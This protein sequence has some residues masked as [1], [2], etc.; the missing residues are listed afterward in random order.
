MLPNY[1]NSQH[2]R[3]HFQ[4]FHE[5]IVNVVVVR[6]QATMKTK[7]FGFV[8]FTS[9]A[10]AAAAI[11]KLNGSKLQGKHELLVQFKHNQERSKESRH[12]LPA[13]PSSRG[14][15]SL[16]SSVAPKGA[17][18]DYTPSDSD[19][20]S[21]PEECVLYIRSKYKVLPDYITR[22]HITEHFK[23]FKKHITN[24][25]IIRDRATNKSKG[26]GFIT[27]SSKASAQ[28]ALRKLN[29]SKLHG[30]F[31]LVIEYKHGKRGAGK[32]RLSVATSTSSASA[33][34]G[35]HTSAEHQSQG[36]VLYIRAKYT[37]LPAYINNQHLKEHFQE[38]KEDIVSA[39]MICDPATRKS[40]G[41]GFITFT[42]VQAA[43][44][45]IQKLNGSK[46]H[47]KFNLLVEF[48][49]RSEFTASPTLIKQPPNHVTVFV[50]CT[51]EQMMYLKLNLFQ[52]T[53]QEAKRLLTSLQ[54]L[55][56]EVTCQQDQILLSGTPVLTEQAQTVILA[57]SLL[58]GLLSHS[59]PFTCHSKFLK[60]IEEHVLEPM[61]REKGLK[62]L[63]HCQEYENEIQGQCSSFTITILSKN[64]AHFQ[65]A[66]MLM[67]PL[68]PQ[69]QRF[70][71]EAYTKQLMPRITEI[72]KKNHRC[73]IQFTDGPT[74]VVQIN[75]LCSHDI[76]SCWKETER[77]MELN[78]MIARRIA[79]ESFQ[80]KY[81]Q[82]KHSELIEKANRVCTLVI[83]RSAESATIG[84]LSIILSGKIVFVKAY[85]ERVEEIVKR[86]T[87]EDVQRLCPTA[88]VSSVWKRRWDSFI[89][90]QQEKYDILVE[91]QCSQQTA[92]KISAST[93]ADVSSVCS[94]GW[95]SFIQELCSQQTA[96]KQLE[97]NA[98]TL[99]TFLVYGSDKIAIRMVKQQILSKS[100]KRL[101][102]SEIELEHLLKGLK[103]KRI[104][105]ES[106]YSVMISVN[107][108]SKEVTL[109]TPPLIKADLSG[110]EEEVLRFIHSYTSITS[111]EMNFDD[112]VI[113]LL[114][115]TS[116]LPQLRKLGEKNNVLVYP[117][118][119]PSLG[120]QLKGTQAA[121][122]IMERGIQQIVSE[123]SRDVTTDQYPVS[124]SYLPMFATPDFTHFVSNLQEELCVACSYPAVGDT[125]SCKV[126]R[127]AALQNPS[128]DVT[129]LQ[130][131]EGSLVKQTVDAIVIEANK[132]LFLTDGLAKTILA[133][134]GPL[135]Q[136]EC[137][138]HIQSK[139]KLQ[140]DT[141][142]CLGSG[143]LPCKKVIHFVYSKSDSTRKLLLAIFCS[144]QCAV[145]NRIGSIAFPAIE[146]KESPQK[147]STLAALQLEAVHAHCTGASGLSLMHSSIHTIR[148]VLSTSQRCEF[149]EAFDSNPHFSVSANARKQPSSV[150]LQ[151]P[152]ASPATCKWFWEDDAKSFSPYPLHISDALTVEYTKNPSGVCSC[153]IDGKLYQIDFQKMK[154]RNVSTGF[155]RN[156]KR[157]QVGD[158]PQ[159]DIQWYYKDDAGH[160]V[161]YSQA[162]SDMIETKYNGGNPTKQRFLL[163][164]HGR[165]YTIDFQSMFQINC[166][167]LH[168][169]SIKREPTKEEEE[170]EE[171]PK[172]R[173]IV[174]NIR[175]CR[176]SLQEARIRIESKLKSLVNKTD[177]PLPPAVPQTFERQLLAVAEKHNLTCRIAEQ[178]QQSQAVAGP[179][180]PKR[181]LRIE[182][183]EHL[184]HKAATE[185]QAEIIQLFQSSRSGADKMSVPPEWQ[186][187]TETVEVFKLQSSSQEWTV[188]SSK[189]SVTMPHVTI[190]KILRI[191]NQWL[192]EKYAQEKSRINQKNAGG[193]NE[194]ELF[195]GTRTNTPEKIYNSEEG[196]DMRYSSQ[197]MWGMANY[198]A[199]NASYSAM[200]AYASISLLGGSS[201][202][203]IF[204]AKVLT[205]D[206]YEC[207]PDKTLRM[208]PQKLGGS[209][210]SEVQLKQV[211]Y[212]SVNGYTRSSQVYMTY[213]NNRAYPAYLIT[214]V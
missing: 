9:H 105:P 45:A 120:I 87:A 201:Q 69:L 154:Q 203:T 177:I 8:T 82:R 175:G 132:D 182:G 204:L 52:E 97:Q 108:A 156:V 4:E 99:V 212:D 150:T 184:V 142:V 191:Q 188:V 115:T 15:S 90:E 42:S 48:Q 3:K 178:Q 40:R 138:T 63:Y 43:E 206:S 78:V 37:V 197:G 11:R 190:T 195:H 144:L 95:D 93:T 151:T 133:E 183:F 136:V 176:K 61:L 124:Y 28:A 66:S 207:E 6:D 55:P 57:S 111:K 23:E 22:Q 148:I 157:E 25:R 149:L 163:T 49:H 160:F 194:M 126:L 179:Q 59:Y 75:G 164:I 173:H 85:A 168:K 137:S 39:R 56:V 210:S 18:C 76:E 114:L 162:D 36:N 169:R 118:A 193:V 98:S 2:L 79:V 77:Y 27:F 119:K 74:P 89:L 20:E 130:I 35:I 170:E 47:G 152:F 117:P 60:Q 116:Y 104:D 166:K 110:A 159:K 53:S 129:I 167:T 192:W 141:A 10:S 64:F 13:V 139:G 165:V 125:N 5:H 198:F 16:S 143:N 62:V 72:G 41:Y 33:S 51:P 185:I 102:L 199:V 109:S 127:Q 122:E 92:N 19:T 46:L 161:P 67:Q 107:K 7:G 84:M 58:R 1:I 200:Y 80:L 54:A 146:I 106:E 174:I 205:G 26:F 181:V 71:V 189:F 209:T 123:I 113:G 34:S 65:E 44:E 103:D 140:P 94:R 31:E 83:P 145:T 100:E 172:P 180:P 153:K 96:K 86:C 91:Y 14:K 121:I 131:C 202:K 112:A 196:F 101:R 134:G 38:F 88:D 21:I 30:K 211:H 214:Y 32:Q 171:S 17:R 70:R 147:I 81:L 155:T 50:K 73:W 29:G 68:N 187:Q 213:S 128:G 24:S 208:P 158:N 135:I 12:S 186:D